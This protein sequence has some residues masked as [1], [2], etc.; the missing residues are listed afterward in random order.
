MTFIVVGWQIDTKCM[1]K[2]EL[3]NIKNKSIISYLQLLGV[4]PANDTGSNLYYY[5]PKRMENTPSLCV[6]KHKNIFRDF[7]SGE[8]AGDIID[9][10][11]YYHN[12]D[13]NEALDI[14]VSGKVKDVDL[15]IPARAQKTSIVKKYVKNIESEH[16]ISYLA[17][18]KLNTDLV[19]S[20]C[21]EIGFSFPNGKYPDTI[22]SAIGMVNNKGGFAMRNSWFKGVLP[23]VYYTR[24][25]RSNKN[26]KVFEGFMNYLSYLILSQQKH[27]NAII[28]N[29]VENVKLIDWRV[30]MGGELY[31]D[32]GTA[33][34]KATNKIREEN[35]TLI[36]SRDYD[37]HE[38]LNK[39]L[40]AA[41]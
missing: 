8:K 37:G 35:L 34:D 6:S 21:R 7:G 24:T 3:Q 16:L 25:S 18:R 41:S 10:V 23:P 40:I 2:E 12:V 30:F 19:M 22:Y 28:L 20:Q 26:V 36:D 5:S 38:D 29:G 27:V 31:L 14:L 32:E 13:F 33:G 39:M 15:N 17:A 11:Q 4:E 9:F 1:T